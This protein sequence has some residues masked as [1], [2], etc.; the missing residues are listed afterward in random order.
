MGLEIELYFNPDDIA[1]L[2]ANH[3]K[4]IFVTI[5]T[6][7]NEDGRA[8]NLVVYATGHNENG[9]SVGNPVPGCPSPCRPFEFDKDCEQK[10]QLIFSNYKSSD[11]L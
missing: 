1:I 8:M 4:K 2:M 5:K 7:V 6:K 3:P 11:F 10:A 9:E